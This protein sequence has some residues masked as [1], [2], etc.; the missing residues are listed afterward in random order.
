MKINLEA[1][2][3]LELKLNEYSKVNGSIAEHKSQNS[4][5]CTDCYSSGGCKG[6]CR[7]TCVSVCKA[8]KNKY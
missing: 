7:G 6:T 5:S 4:N 8:T 1:L 2:N 3:A